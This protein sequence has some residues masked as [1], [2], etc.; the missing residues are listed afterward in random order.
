MFLKI[1]KETHIA[2][3]VL[4]AADP[5]FPGTFPSPV[6]HRLNGNPK[7][8]GST[9]K[10]T[11]KLT[12]V[13]FSLLYLASERALHA[14][15]YVVNAQITSQ[16]AGD[17][18]Y[19]YTI[20]LNNNSSA[21]EPIETFWF[22]WSPYYYGYD[23]LTS[24]PTITQTPSGWAGYVN[25]DNYYYPDGYSLEFYNY[26]TALEPGNSLDFGFNS[27]DSPATLLQ[28]SPFY[29]IPTLTSYVYTSYAQYDPGAQLLVTPAA[30]PE[31]ST[32]GLTGV[33]AVGLLFAA[34]RRMSLL[35]K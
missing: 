20:Q 26:S 5:F 27:P 17:G 19:N 3:S 1:F 6:H 8:K 12:L 10:N 2:A 14:Q 30:V 24:A 7:L 4:A 11:L 22:A 13:S 18:T 15:G 25:N 29:N 32:I 33:C 34:R 9:M 28:N 16:A 23:L 35:N 21:T 31:P